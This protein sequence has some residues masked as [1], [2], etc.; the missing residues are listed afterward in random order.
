MLDVGEVQ[1]GGRLVEHEHAAPFTQVGGQFEPLALTPGQGGQGLA[2][3]DVPQPD[4]DE[5]GEDLVGRRKRSLTVAEEPLRLV[6]RHRQYLCDVSPGQGVLE[7]LRL[8]PLALAVLTRGG[9]AGHHAQIGV[10]HAGALALGT[11]ALGVGAEQRRLHVVGLGERLADR[12]EQLGVGGRVAA[13]GTLDRAL[14]HL[15]HP[16]A[17]RQRS[18]EERALARPGHAGDDDQHP[19]GDVDV[20]I[21]QV[22][23]VGA[24]DLQHTLRCPHR[25]FERCPVVQMATGD[26]VA[27]AQ[28]LDRALEAHVASAR[29][30]TGAQVDDV[31][32]D[33][34]RLGIVLDDQHGVALVPQPQQQRVHARHIVGMQP[35]RRFVEDVG[36]VGERRAEVADHLDPLRLTARQRAGGPVEAEVAQ[37]DVLKRVEHV[38]EPREQRRNRRLVEPGDPAGQ[39][40]DLHRAQLGDVG[41]VDRRGSGLV[42]QPGAVAPGAG[43][44][45]HR[46][47]DKA[48]DVGEHRLDVLGQDRLA[49]LS[50][51]TQIGQ[52]GA[53]H[54]DLGRLL[55]QE[56]VE[57][58]GAELDDRLVRVEPAAAAIDPAVPAVHAVAGDGDRPLVERLGGVEDRRQVD[59]VDRSHA[60]AARAHAPGDR[61][62]A[63]LAGRSPLLLE[64]DPPGA[65]DRGHVERIGLG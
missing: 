19:E 37:A 12:V 11:G 6:D 30:G 25:R 29:A 23:S 64:A 42:A 45:R 20:D 38:P 63:G 24:P 58:G 62:A 55:V 41:A 48:A 32:G 3:P 2:Q 61:E 47:L 52:V 54:L 35:D 51:E 28:P 16:V 65:A 59:V 22:V 34:D 44:E 60:L 7:H 18:V 4:V 27:R 43:R 53:V 46:P 49:H 56:V 13:P 10:E 39:V 9:H 33:G 17:P 21:D 14:V 57:F 26:R 50:D 1:P 5:P 8:K 40:T 31:V 15:D 36:D